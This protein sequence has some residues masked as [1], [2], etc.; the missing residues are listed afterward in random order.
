MITR[1]IVLVLLGLLIAGLI[2]KWMGPA[3]PRD[4]RGPPIEPARKCPDCDAYVLG[5]SPEP[6]ERS[7]CPF[8]VAHAG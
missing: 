4:R 7:D 5:A 8:R 2:R 3:L 1:L 6:C